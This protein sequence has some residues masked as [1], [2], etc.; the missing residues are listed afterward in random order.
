[1]HNDVHCAVLCRAE[2][3]PSC[4]VQDELVPL[5]YA[6]AKGHP[7]VARVL[8]ARGARCSR[9]DKVGRVGGWVRGGECPP[10]LLPWPI[11]NRSHFL[12]CSYI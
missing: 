2:R 12:S 5:H 11:P 8:L 9:A 3:L 6:A 10:A 4:G 1:M 7:E